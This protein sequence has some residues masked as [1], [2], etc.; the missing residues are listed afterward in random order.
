MEAFLGTGHHPR[1]EALRAHVLSS[2]QPGGQGTE[3]VKKLG[4]MGQVLGL[5]DFLR[6]F[7]GLGNGEHL[8]N[9][10]KGGRCELGDIKVQAQVHD[11]VSKRPRKGLCQLLWQAWQPRRRLPDSSWVYVTVSWRGTE[12]AKVVLVEE[13]AGSGSALTPEAKA[14]GFALVEDGPSVGAPGSG[15][16]AAGT[17]EEPFPGTGIEHLPG[18]PPCHPDPR[19][20]ESP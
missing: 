3:V 5:P 17:P 6:Q 9:P 14:P 2:R 1:R 15:L 8:H 19:A 11:I 13:G 18:L 16:G 20:Q 4:S 12:D 10:C 7:L